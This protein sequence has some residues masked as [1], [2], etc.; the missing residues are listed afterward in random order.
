M[1]NVISRR[2]IKFSIY[3]LAFLSRFILILVNWNIFKMD[4]T[5]RDIEEKCNASFYVHIR[6]FF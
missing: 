6:Q 3:P 5:E 4:R 2:D 1:E